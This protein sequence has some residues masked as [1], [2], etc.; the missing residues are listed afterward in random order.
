MFVD[1]SQISRY[2][3]L[4]L[5]GM[6]LAVDL[7]VNVVS[8]ALAPATHIPQVQIGILVAAACLAAITW[9]AREPW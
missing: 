8:P 2:V 4:A 1:T 5:T 6:L 3:Y 7:A 9:L